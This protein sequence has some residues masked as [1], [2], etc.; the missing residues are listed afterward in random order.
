[1]RESEK[2]PQRE[3]L[4]AAVAP[5]TGLLLGG[6]WF[7]FLPLVRT[8]ENHRSRGYCH[9]GHRI[10]DMSSTCLTSCSPQHC[11]H[12]S[13]FPHRAFGL[14]NFELTL[15]WSTSSEFDAQAAVPL[16]VAPLLDDDSSEENTPL[17]VCQNCGVNIGIVDPTSNRAASSER[18][19]KS[20]QQ[21]T[22]SHGPKCFYG[23][24]YGIV[25]DV[26]EFKNIWVLSNRAMALTRAKTTTTTTSYLG[27]MSSTSTSHPIVFPL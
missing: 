10:P 9:L 27:A 5:L 14:F 24:F 26:I 13:V 16:P 22:I 4:P 21:C 3:G 25:V 19:Q 7:R 8:F 6:L 2:P 17:A 1:V 20:C 12:R 15:G 23:K 18:P 11:I